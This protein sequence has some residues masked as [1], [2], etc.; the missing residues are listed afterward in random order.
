MR[1]LSNDFVKNVDNVIWQQVKVSASPYV[2][3]SWCVTQLYAQEITYNNIHMAALVMQVDGFNFSGFALVALNDG[4]DLYDIFTA[5][6]EDAELI[7]HQT[8]VYCDSL[9]HALDT[10]IEKG[11]LTEEQYE[12]RIKEAYSLV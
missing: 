12:R 9:A 6:T 1:Q 2:I 10:L 4:K 11:D 5:E 8:D 7:C 3:G